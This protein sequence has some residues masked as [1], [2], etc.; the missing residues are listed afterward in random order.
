MR[1][2]PGD[3]PVEHQRSHEPVDG[4]GAREHGVNR[5]DDVCRAGAT[6]SLILE[7][8][9]HAERLTHVDLMQPPQLAADS[10]S[11]VPLDDE[12]P[13]VVEAGKL[14]RCRE[15][16]EPPCGLQA[17]VL[18]EVVMCDSRDRRLE[19]VRGRD[20]PGRPRPSVGRSMQ[21]ELGLGACEREVPTS[22]YRRLLPCVWIG[23]QVTQHLG[24]VGDSQ[25]LKGPGV[26]FT[27]G[28]RRYELHCPS[29]VRTDV[30]QNRERVARRNTKE[31]TPT[32]EDLVV[33][34]QQTGDER[35]HVSV[36]VLAAYDGQ[37]GRQRRRVCRVVRVVY[38]P[39]PTVAVLG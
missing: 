13:L 6:V 1:V 12:H 28:L 30:S 27:D 23:P 10:A 9:H 2:G 20:S 16:S 32:I 33:V 14:G 26:E 31:S 8:G 24:D 15:Q 35:R 19:D 5:G 34:W 38:E 22:C 3:Q 11:V 18:V 39:Q 29:A 17:Q 37:P 4:G 7:V 21:R 36:G 25:R